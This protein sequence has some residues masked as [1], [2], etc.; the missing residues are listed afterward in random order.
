[1]ISDRSTAVKVV[2]L[3]LDAFLRVDE[4]CAT[5]RETCSIEEA[6][7]FQKTTAPIVGAIVMEILEPLYNEHP[8]FKPANW[9]D[10]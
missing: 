9:V 2:E 5:V 1:M 7:A 3:M 6:D 4:C 10:M 8:D